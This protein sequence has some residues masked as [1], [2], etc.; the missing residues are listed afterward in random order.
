MSI[1]IKPLTASEV[2]YDIRF[3]IGNLHYS[4]IYVKVSVIAILAASEAMAASMASEV[5]FEICNLIYSGIQRSQKRLAPLQVMG[6][7]SSCTCLTF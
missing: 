1:A 7:I 5:R 6:E 2:K 3:K 4:G